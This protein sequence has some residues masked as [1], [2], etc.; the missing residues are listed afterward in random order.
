MNELCLQFG[1]HY[2]VFFRYPVNEGVSL[3]DHIGV[4]RRLH[5]FTNRYIDPFYEYKPKVILK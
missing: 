4:Y 3:L 5:P 1:C 2:R